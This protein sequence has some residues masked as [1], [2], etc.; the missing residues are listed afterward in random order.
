MSFP[1]KPREISH[2]AL[3][4]AGLLV[5][6]GGMG[7]VFFHW[8][9]V[10]MHHGRDAGTIDFSPAVA[11][12]A[13][14]HPALIA[15]RSPAVLER[16]QQ[17]YLKNCA[18]CHGA[19]GD[20]NMTGSSPAPRNLKSENYKAEWGGGPYGFF[21]TLTKGW[22][23]GMPGFTNLEAT[24][25][26]AI[27]HFVRESWQKSQPIYLAEDKPEI[28]AQIPKP[29]AVA[30]GPRVAP[31][32]VEQHARLHPLMAVA[33]REGEARA[34]AARAWLSEAAGGAETAERRLLARLAKAP[35]QRAGW[36][37]Q[38]HEA[39]RSGDRLRVAAVL[40]SPDS[41][42]PSLALEPAISIDAAAGV[43][44]AAAGQKA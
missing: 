26:Y 21:L 37:V 34:S 31:H 36:L 8:L 29:G 16:G 42:D 28:Q 22:G 20:K 9:G 40:I 41:G 14:D 35:V 1:A 32:L 2:P 44:V 6:A 19:D 23:Q 3:W 39:A 4:T 15:D 33:A 12:A 18:S 11:A 43:L 17:L 27:A 38:L 13:I 10:G 5:A 30:D 24:D 7:W 25:R